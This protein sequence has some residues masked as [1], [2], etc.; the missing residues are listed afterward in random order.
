M[1]PRLGQTFDVALDACTHASSSESVAKCCMFIMLTLGKSR[2]AMMKLKN[3]LSETAIIHNNNN[4][5]NNNSS[6]NNN[7]VPSRAKRKGGTTPF[8]ARV[9]FGACRWRLKAFSCQVF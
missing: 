8:A 2:R 1:G 3:A 4:N 9:G 6:S 7:N 5:N